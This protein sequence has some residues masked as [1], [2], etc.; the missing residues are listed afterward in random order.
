MKFIFWKK[1]IKLTESEKNQLAKI[2][3]FLDSVS[4]TMIEE[5]N[6]VLIG[7]VGLNNKFSK[8]DIAELVFEINVDGYR[9]NLYPM[10]ANNTQLGHK[11]ILTKYPNGLIRDMDLDIDAD[12]YD[13]DNDADMDRM[14]EFYEQ[15]Q[16]KV[17]DWFN[18]CF[19]NAG[20]LKVNEKYF[21]SVH[22]S[23]KTYDLKC[24]IWVNN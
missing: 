12:D 7:D 18:A 19:I 6:E 9:I 4:N 14:D 3:S 20:G 1:N 5:I 10:D 17:M 8:T 23:N 11:K 22:D 24:Q 2:T 13:F 15:L 16:T 21:I